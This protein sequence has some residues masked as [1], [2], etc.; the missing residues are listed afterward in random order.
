ML[1][2]IKS[3]DFNSYE[4]KIKNRNKTK[5]MITCWDISVISQRASMFCFCL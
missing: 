1:F 5:Y 4:H 2:I 3:Y